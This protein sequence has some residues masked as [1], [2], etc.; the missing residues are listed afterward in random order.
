MP[1]QAKKLS[2][3]IS[4]TKLFL[5]ESV[6]DE[7]LRYVT[8]YDQMVV[9]RNAYAGVVYFAGFGFE[10]E[11]AVPF[12]MFVKLG[13]LLDKST[14]VDVVVGDNQILWKLGRY[15]YK[16]GVTVLQ[17]PTVILPN[18]D[19]IMAVTSDFKSILIAASFAA[20]LDARQ[21][22]LHGVQIGGGLIQACDNVRAYIEKTTVLDATASL[23]IPRELLA[24]LVGIPHELCGIA[25]T[26]NQMY[27]VYD[28]FIIFS[29]LLG[30]EYPKLDILFDKPN[31]SDCLG[32]ITGY[33]AMRTELERFAAI[34]RRFG[35][36]AMVRVNDNKL[37]I[38]MDASSIG[39]SEEFD[40]TIDV[41]FSVDNLEFKINSQYFIDGLIRFD[42][43]EI[44]QTFVYFT[45]SGGIEHIIMLMQ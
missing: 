9:A 18:P 24:I 34:G 42:S 30:L 4:I 28:Q 12:D 2:D 10:K 25:V 45:N 13:T 1:I 3:V 37:C 7:S 27:F 8:F 43:C 29:A 31:Q 14:V 19:Q 33:G 11:F 40:L 26:D 22:S 21:P 36:S 16:T 32:K 6:I 20:S 35:Y 23:F 38:A 41:Q 44:Y 5:S 17:E 15:R 39:P